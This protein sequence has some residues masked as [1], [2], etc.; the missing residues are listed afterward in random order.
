VSLEREKRNDFGCV[1]QMKLANDDTK[2]AV[3]VNL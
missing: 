3:A 1:I 2:G